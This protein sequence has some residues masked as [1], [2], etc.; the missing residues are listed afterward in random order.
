M[1]AGGV[2]A[3]GGVVVEPLVAAGGVSRAGSVQLERRR[4]D[5]GVLVARHEGLGPVA[6]VAAKRVKTHG[7]VAAAQ[8]CEVACI[9]PDEGVAGP[10][11]VNERSRS[12]ENISRRCRRGL[13]HNVPC[14]RHRRLQR[15][16]AARVV[17]HCS[18]HRAEVVVHLGG[19]RRRARSE[20]RQRPHRAGMAD[21]PKTHCQRSDRQSFQVRIHK[22]P[23]NRLSIF[24]ASCFHSQLQLP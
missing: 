11:V 21:L 8:H 7:G 10:E 3:A 5:G 16:D 9:H 1:T 17:V 24:F 13:Q 12:L 14:G 22:S 23:P 2:K 18:P 15:A 4:S 19:L 6:C 20:G